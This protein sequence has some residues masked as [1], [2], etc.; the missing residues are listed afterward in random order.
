MTRDVELEVV[1]SFERIFPVPTVVA[2]WEDVVD[3]ARA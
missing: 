2:D 1:D 3:R